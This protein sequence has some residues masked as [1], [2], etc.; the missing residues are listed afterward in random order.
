MEHAAGLP[1]LPDDVDQAALAFLID[2]AIANGSLSCYGGGERRKAT[3]ISAR[4]RGEAPGLM[5]FP[6]VT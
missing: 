3:K 5:L 1:A 2:D 6:Q 4:G